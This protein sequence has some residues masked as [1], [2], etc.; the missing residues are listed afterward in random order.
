MSRERIR[1]SAVPH[2]PR[3]HDRVCAP[4]TQAFFL[5]RTVW[6]EPSVGQSLRNSLTRRYARYAG[7]VVPIDARWRWDPSFLSTKRTSDRLHNMGTWVY[8]ARS[9]T[10]WPPTTHTEARSS[11][12]CGRTA[13]PGPHIRT[14]PRAQA[15]CLDQ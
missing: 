9:D 10:S 14:V 5:E 15:H 7:T 4:T 1:S 13:P 2:A 11:A 12:R 3:A 6:K 8:N